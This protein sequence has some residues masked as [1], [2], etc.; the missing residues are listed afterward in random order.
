MRTL[1]PGLAPGVGLQPVSSVCLPLRFPLP[2]T[3]PCAGRLLLQVSTR[4]T[5]GETVG[6][7]VLFCIFP[8]PREVEHS[9]LCPLTAQAASSGTS[10]L[11]PS[12]VGLLDCFPSP[13]SALRRAQGLSRRLGFKTRAWGS[14]RVPVTRSQHLPRTFR[15]KNGFHAFL[16]YVSKYDYDSWNSISIGWCISQLL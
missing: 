11:V 9:L 14:W 12:S 7:I 15:P 16:F 1:S 5:S 8:I 13:A 6:H 3:G 4:Q 10:Y 2:V